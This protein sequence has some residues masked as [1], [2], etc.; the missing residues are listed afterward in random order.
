MKVEHQ[1]GHTQKRVKKKE[2]RKRKGRAK[3]KKSE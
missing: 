2:K 1:R 3:V